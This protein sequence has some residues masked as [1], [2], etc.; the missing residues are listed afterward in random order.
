MGTFLWV[1]GSWNTVQHRIC[2]DKEKSMEDYEIVH[3]FI[4]SE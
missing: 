1:F 2:I 4:E 3:K